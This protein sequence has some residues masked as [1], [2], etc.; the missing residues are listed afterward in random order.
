MSWDFTEEHWHVSKAQKYIREIQWQSSVLRRT[1][2]RG[3]LREEK[4]EGYRS[5]SVGS[6]VVSYVQHTSDVE[7]VRILHQRMD[8]G[9]LLWP[10]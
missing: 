10:S 9:R 6:H 2:D 5:Y 3:R 4:C 1:T 8:I 7:V